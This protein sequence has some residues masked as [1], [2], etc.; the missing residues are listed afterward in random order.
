MSDGRASYLPPAG[1]SPGDI[2]ADRDVRGS[3]SKSAGQMTGYELDSFVATG[4]KPSG[5]I[6]M[7]TITATDGEQ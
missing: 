3:A 2:S 6:R 1:L 5:D 7:A 4:D